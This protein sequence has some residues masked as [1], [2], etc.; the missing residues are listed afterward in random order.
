MGK[1]TKKNKAK[2]KAAAKEAAAK[3]AAASNPTNA[4]DE[5]PADSIPSVKPEDDAVAGETTK[6]G[7][8]EVSQDTIVWLV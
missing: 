7:D 2:K 3:E 6:G 4:V 8:A 5:V 1:N